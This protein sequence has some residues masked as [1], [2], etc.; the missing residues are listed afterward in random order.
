MEDVSEER[1]DTARD[2]DDAIIDDGEDGYPGSV[3]GFR[4]RCPPSAILFACNESY[5][6]AAE[7]YPRTFATVGTL[8]TIWFNFEKDVLYLNLDSFKER[9]GDPDGLLYSY[10]GWLT[11]LVTIF[12]EL[13]ILLYILK[14]VAPRFRTT[15]SL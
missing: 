7:A 8:P 5:E 1:P 13:K 15:N 9:H 11:S 3:W 2:G 14:M 12:E 6:V 10:M 4:T